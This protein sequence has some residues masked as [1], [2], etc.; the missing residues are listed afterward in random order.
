MLDLLTQLSDAL[1]DSDSEPVKGAKKVTLQL[2]NRA[3]YDTQN[4]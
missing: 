2:A 4:G 1:D 3:K